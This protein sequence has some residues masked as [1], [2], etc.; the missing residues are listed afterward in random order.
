MG[1]A[2]GHHDGDDVL[3]MLLRFLGVTA[4]F[5]LAAVFMP[6]SWMGET[7]RWLGL[8]EMPTSPIVEY[9]ARSNSVFYVL[10]GAL[11][12]LVASDLERYRPLVR[13][14]AAAFALTGLVLIGID[15]AAGLPSWWSAFEGP[16]AIG[17]GA[18]MFFLGHPSRR[19]DSSA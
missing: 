17:V 16:P 5:A 10:F 8:G 19:A 4:L 18:M 9:L 2:I 14:L 7:H 6:V 1:R 13:F 3:V 11:F 15:V 12:L